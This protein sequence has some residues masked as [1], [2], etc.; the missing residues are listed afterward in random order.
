MAEERSTETR[1]IEYKE[2]DTMSF[3][4]IRMWLEALVMQQGR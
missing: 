4:P 3:Y 2:T 1:A